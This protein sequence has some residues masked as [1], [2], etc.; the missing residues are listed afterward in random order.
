MAKTAKFAYLTQ[1]Y[2]YTIDW[3]VFSV[4]FVVWQFVGYGLLV[5]I[6]LVYIY[7]FVTE[8]IE[9]RKRKAQEKLEKE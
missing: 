5:T 4:A 7:L 3:L 1:I 2:Q 6:Q 8:E 9:E